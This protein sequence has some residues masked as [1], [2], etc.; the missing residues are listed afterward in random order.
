MKIKQEDL[1]PG[2]IILIAKNANLIVG[3]VEHKTKSGSIRYSWDP[4]SP[5]NEYYDFQDKPEKFTK[6]AN[7][8]K[9]WKPEYNRYFWLLSRENGTG[10]N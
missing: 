8:T 5:S 6:T 10:G 4:T 3:K 1:Q 7:I 2:D 9:A